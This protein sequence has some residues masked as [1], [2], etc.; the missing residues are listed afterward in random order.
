MMYTCGICTSYVCCLGS[1]LY[2]SVFMSYRDLSHL[3][4]TLQNGGLLLSALDMV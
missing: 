2:S 1:Y 3:R 4:F